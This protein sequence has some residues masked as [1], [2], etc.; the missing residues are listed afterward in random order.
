MN[1]STTKVEN[2]NM[3]ESAFGRP[4]SWWTAWPAVAV[5]LTAFLLAV[6]GTFWLPGKLPTQ[7][8]RALE[9]TQ[10]RYQQLTEKA[11]GGGSERLIEVAG[12]MDVIYSRL[13]GLEGNSPKRYWQWAEFQQL[14]SDRLNRIL[15]DPSLS[16]PP[17]VRQR[18]AEQADR[19]QAKSHETL[20]QLALRPSLLQ[21]RSVLQVAKRKYREG[22]SEFGVT[23]ARGLADSL[24]SVLAEVQAGVDQSGADRTAELTAQ[25]IHAARLLLVQLHIEAAWQIQPGSSLTCDAE[26]LETAWELLQDYYPRRAPLPGAGVLGGDTDGGASS[27]ID[28]QWRATR[29]LLAAMTGRDL[30]EPLPGGEQVAAKKRPLNSQRIWSDELARLQLAALNEEWSAMA[31]QLSMRAGH[32]DAA[33][34]SGLARTVCRLVVSPFANAAED[35]DL[36]ILLAAQLAPHLPETAELIWEC[37]RLQAG[38]E[39]ERVHLPDSVAQAMMAGQSGWLK[40]SLA[41]LTATL[42]DKPNV[43]STHLQLLNRTQS[44]ASLV[45][46]VALWRSQL[47][48]MP[49]AASDTAEQAETEPTEERESRQR[50]LKRLIELLNSAVQVEPESGLNWFVLGTLQF[51]AGEF[52]NTRTSLTKAQELLGQVPAIEQMLDAAGK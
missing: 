4:A 50:E 43:A 10:Q 2:S 17:A 48:A 44:N 30:D 37:A 19:F 16:L 15:Q 14:H 12:E 3:H 36:A 6:Y 9:Q 41:A 42:E 18:W 7:Y 46:R 33:V 5:G 8:T 25:E 22:V 49:E 1:D 31:G 21:A 47:L 23:E 13:V 20:D 35:A 45:A 51:R 29:G 52:D 27:H 24:A 38:Q 39:S 34:T 40:H 11:S 32:L 28:G 26:R